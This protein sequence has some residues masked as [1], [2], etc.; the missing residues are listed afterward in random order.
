MKVP[1]FGFPNSAINYENDCLFVISNSLHM[2]KAKSRV[3]HIERE[4]RNL[5][6]VTLTPSFNNM[7]TTA[8]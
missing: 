3:A 5:C 1:K 4:S 6:R 8:H 2:L 7:I